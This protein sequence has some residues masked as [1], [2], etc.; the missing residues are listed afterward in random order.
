MSALTLEQVTPKQM[1]LD[2]HLVKSS[3]EGLPLPD[4]TC[5]HAYSATTME[6]IDAVKSAG[7]MALDCG[8]GLRDF[9]SPHLVQ[10]DIY[11]FKNVD[12]IA[13]AERLPF[14][15]QCFDAVFSYDVLEHVSDPFK[16]ASEIVR[17]L[18]P[19]GVLHVDVPFLQTEHGY[20]NHYFNMTRAGL[21]ALFADLTCEAHVVP[22]SGCAHATA[23]YV[24]AALRGGMTKAARPD[25]DKMTIGEFLAVSPKEL[26]KMLP[27]SAEANWQ[28]ASA[29]Q[30][31]FRK[32]GAMRLPVHAADLPVFRLN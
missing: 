13:S 25:F 1:W 8:S 2:R 11:P 18:K 10:L 16:A 30:A 19:G 26:F 31:L 24:L 20:P 17:V 6:L 4:R 7:G 32:P 12:V 21:R 28:A 3:F 27:I 23:W 14:V 22:R 9:T 29:T 15:D 5:G